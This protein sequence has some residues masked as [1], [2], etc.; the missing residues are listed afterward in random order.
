MSRLTKLGWIMPEY[1]RAHLENT[2]RVDI[3]IVLLKYKMR[4]NDPALE[5]VDD[6]HRYISEPLGTYITH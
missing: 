1:I 2:K 6:Y 4:S 5:N 3:F